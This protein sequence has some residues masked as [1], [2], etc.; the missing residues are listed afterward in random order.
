MLL[1]HPLRQHSPF[2][3]LVPQ[4]NSWSQIDVVNG[5]LM[6]CGFSGLGHQKAVVLRTQLLRVDSHIHGSI[7]IR[8]LI[9]PDYMDQSKFH[10][11]T[12]ERGSP[13]FDLAGPELFY[14][15]QL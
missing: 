10:E 1:L 8:N 4:V 3:L 12:A 15:R 7:K 11:E 13:P 5:Q 9:R 2:Q 6:E 14:Y